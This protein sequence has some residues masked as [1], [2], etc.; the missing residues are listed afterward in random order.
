MA[1]ASAAVSTCSAGLCRS[2]VRRS[3]MAVLCARFVFGVVVF[4]GEQEGMIRISGKG[5]EIVA[6]GEGAIP[7]DKGIV[8]AVKEFPGLGDAFLPAR[9]QAGS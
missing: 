5:P 4:K 2:S 7:C 3:K 8:D 9:L 1:S 6:G